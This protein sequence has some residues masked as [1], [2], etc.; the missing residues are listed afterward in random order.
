MTGP[1]ATFTGTSTLIVHA[2]E[3]EVPIDPPQ[4]RHRVA[5]HAVVRSRVIL[6]YIA[7]VVV[8]EQVVHR[9]SEAKLN[10]MAVK[11]EIHWI[12]LFRIER[13]ER[14]AGM[15]VEDGDEVVFV[16]QREYSPEQPTVRSIGQERAV[17]VRAESAGSTSH[18]RRYMIAAVNAYIEGVG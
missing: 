2:L 3:V 10:T 13:R 15:H 14:E 8:V 7:R 5:E 4:P 1:S 18:C 16:G 6:L 9:Q 11:L 17:L 12:L